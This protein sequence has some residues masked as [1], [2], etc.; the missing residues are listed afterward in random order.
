MDKDEYFTGLRTCRSLLDQ[1]IFDL[2]EYVDRVTKLQNIFYGIENSNPCCEISLEP[3]NDLSN[4][5]LRY[6]IMQESKVTK[7]LIK[8]LI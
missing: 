2:Q 4:D 6:A 8:P 1:R 5:A 3:I 7:I